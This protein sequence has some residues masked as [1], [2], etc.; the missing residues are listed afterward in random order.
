MADPDIIQNMITQLGQ[1]QDDRLPPE[2]DPQF[3]QVDARGPADM[4]AQA[5]ALAAKLRYYDQ[6]PARAA[7]DWSAF[8]PAGD[9]AAL[10]ARED[11]QVPPHLGLFASFLQL[12]Q[13]PRAAI[14]TLTGR[15]LDFQLKDVLRFTPRPAAPDHAHVIVEL[16]KGAAPVAL[17]RDLVFSAG[18]D[19]NGVEMRYQP[20]REVIVGQG[21]VAALHSVYHAAQGVFFA[22]VANSADGLGGA[23]DASQPK[24]PPFGNAQLPAAQIGCAFASPVLRMAEGTRQVKLD[25]RLANLDARHT[26]DALAAAFD[27]YL[28]GAKGW[29]GPFALSGSLA[30]DRLS[31]TFALAA[32]DAAVI[33]YDATLHGHAF[34]AQAPVL[35]LILRPDAA[36]RYDDLTALRLGAARIQVQVDGVQTLAL[37]NDNGSLNPK[38]AFQPFGPQPVKGARFMIGSDEA[39]AK[40]LLDLKIKLGWQGA[41]SSLT[42]WYSDYK[43]A[44]TMNDG[45]TAHLIYEDRS[46]QTKS[47]ELDLMARDASG[48]STLSPSA[49]PPSASVATDDIRLFGLRFGGSGIARWLATRFA[50]ARPMY[51]RE[52]VPAPG[53]RSGYVTVALVDDFLHADYRKETMQHALAQDGVVLNEPYTPTVQTISLGY[54]AQSDEVDMSADD[55]DS[56]TNPDL[57]FFLVD[58]FGQMRDHAF[59][60]QQLDY[61][62][63]KQVAL[64]P[65]YPN[66]GEFIIGLQ[67]VAAGDAA[68]LL[69]QVAEGSADP[70]LPAQK[71]AWSVLCDNYWRAL[72]PQELSLDSSRDLRASGIVGL[73]LP[74]E[75]TTDNT[76]LP[77]GCVWLRASAAIDSAAACQLI[78][79]QANAVEVVFVDQGNDPAHLAQALPASSIA[80]LRTP[81]AAVKK[82]TQPYASFDGAQEET[83]SMLVRRAAE[84][85]RHRNRCLSAWDYERMLLEAFPS[86]H[87]V[88]CIPHASDSSWLAP[89][90]V[91]L[92]AIPDLRNRNAVDPLRPRVD[93]DTLTRMRDYAQQHCGMQVTL[94]VKNPDYQRVRLDFKLRLRPGYAFNYYR[95]Q[96]EQALIRALSPWAFDATRQ[97]DFGG[98]LY[99]SVLLDLVEELEWV[100]YV[101]DFKMGLVRDD[102]NPLQDVAE[103][104]ASTPD[105]I[106]VSDASHAI[107][108]ITDA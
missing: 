104:T 90:H 105:A 22:P 86:V 57:Q 75:T 94:K 5:R 42:S 96:T 91:M 60:R 101:T 84:R 107:A 61:V 32:T 85:L 80:K 18:K 59:Q 6:T 71:L 33:D 48:M 79:V 81:V 15:H 41:P 35:Q 51:Q 58:C 50:L 78:D 64:L 76:L 1:S 55:L 56:F 66:E 37:E 26:P 108:E 39:L 100:D 99:R 13:Y 28:S 54:T 19:A 53:A 10:L 3:A 68:S 34:A 82:L 25:M 62:Q 44:S 14:N 65:A 36:L 72:T 88:K 89:G 12:Y 43:H 23:L 30:G 45:V 77:A 83:D 46:G 8:F 70:E 93:I 11:G 103:L 74:A 27:A 102:G 69:M 73:T 67:G 95:Q 52:F 4:L 40:R 29:L 63:D 31:L 17:G 49:P 98:T 38:K 7:G 9:D 87:K 2:L 97:I 20:V 24:W 47:I 21:K 92:V 16:K 106:L